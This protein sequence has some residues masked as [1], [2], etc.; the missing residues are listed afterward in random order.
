MTTTS[1]PEASAPGREVSEPGR[2]S[3]PSEPSPSYA[4]RQPN[5]ALLH[6]AG[7]TAFVGMALLGR[8]TM[9][10]GA[11]IS[12]LWPAGGVAAVWLFLSPGRHVWVALALLGTAAGL[13]NYLTGAGAGLT[14][15]FVVSNVLQAAVFLLVVRR[16]V[17]TLWGRGGTTSLAGIVPLS[18][19]TMAALVAAGAGATAGYLGGNLVRADLPLELWVIWWGRN[20]AGVLSV[21]AV[22]HLV[23]SRVLQVGPSRRVPGTTW[24][25]M[26]VLTFAVYVPLFGQDTYSFAFLALSTTVV[27]GLRSDAVVAVAHALLGGAIAVV[28]TMRGHGPFSLTPD[29]DQQALL[30]Q[31]FLTSALL[32]GVFLSA[33]R[34]ERA[35]SA[36]AL[37]VEREQT[38]QQAE[39]LSSAFDKVSDALLVVGAE[40]EILTANPSAR[41]FLDLLATARLEEV[42]GTP[43]RTIDGTP[44]PREQMPAIR[45]LRGEAVTREDVCITDRDG[46]TH[47]L[48]VSA[49]PL[50]SAGRAKVVASFRDVTDARAQVAELSAFAG[51][52]AHDLRGPLTALQGW[53]DL[54]Q[55]VVA[56]EP[57][58]PRDLALAVERIRSSSVRLAELLEA[59]LVHATSHDRE[60]VREPVDLA[61]TVREVAA[62]RGIDGNVEVGAVPLVLGDAVMLRHLVDNL[63]ANA[64]KYVD[65]GVVPHVVVTGRRVGSQVEVCVCDNGIGVP[66]DMRRAVFQRFQRV[67]GTGRSGT[68]LGLSICQ[69]IVERHGGE[70]SVGPGPGGTGSTFTVLLPAAAP[71]GNPREG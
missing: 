36:A 61:V 43:M 56:G 26:V 65:D 50:T 64:V 49:V 16:T 39:L 30:L 3:A 28:L 4:G 70:I 35:L 40:G 9:L 44:I 71:Q 69:T 23:A 51:V 63:V 2:S 47:T 52:V 7:L 62:T 53:A 12:L 59:L 34:E 48:N 24:L 38:A 11:A 25:S 8:A 10:D 32:T 17:P 41:S 20:F 31:L 57:D 21:F 37:A 15:V 68:G 42:G 22:V 29:A 14:A 55:Q 66:Q 54:A 58:V 18:W 13:T 1:A 45:A 46:L 6:L 5:P 27:V 33:A 60:L 19:V 67:A